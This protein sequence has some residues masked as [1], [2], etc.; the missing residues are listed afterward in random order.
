M[1]LVPI[2]RRICWLADLSP[3]QVKQ[4]LSGLL[5]LLQCNI[6]PTYLIEGHK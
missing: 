5:T 6:T 1:G 2:A 3:I 4:A